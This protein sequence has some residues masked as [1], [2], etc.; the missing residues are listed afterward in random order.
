MSIRFVYVDVYS[1][2]AILLAGGLGFTFHEF[3]RLSAKSEALIR[4]S[5][6]VSKDSQ[7]GMPLQLDSSDLTLGSQARYSTTTGIT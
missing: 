5:N 4:K 6:E 2:V 1:L 7:K 3:R